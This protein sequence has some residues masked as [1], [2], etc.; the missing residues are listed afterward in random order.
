MMKTHNALLGIED[1]DH[2]PA[3]RP[4]ESK[5]SLSNSNHSHTAIMA[6]TDQI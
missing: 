4:G 1:A 6:K 2:H 3:W 5:G